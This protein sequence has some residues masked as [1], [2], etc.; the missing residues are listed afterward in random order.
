MTV[1]RQ[2]T[3]VMLNLVSQNRRSA[4]VYDEKDFHF[5]IFNVIA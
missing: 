3:P 2:V 4:Q 1:R 5:P